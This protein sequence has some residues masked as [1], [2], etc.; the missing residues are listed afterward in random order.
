MVCA[1]CVCRLLTYFSFFIFIFCLCLRD[2]ELLKNDLSLIL[3]NCEF[4]ALLVLSF[5]KDAA[6]SI[7][8][9]LNTQVSQT[10]LEVSLSTSWLLLFFCY[11]ILLDLMHAFG[12]K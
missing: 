3:V 8:T 6:V 2:P 9:A 12:Q 10:D 5:E 11:F 1:L 4:C 7:L